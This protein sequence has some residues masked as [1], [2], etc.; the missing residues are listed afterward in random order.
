VQQQVGDILGPLQGWNYS[1]L[2][3]PDQ[4]GVQEVR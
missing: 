2:V 3:Y 1:A 4:G